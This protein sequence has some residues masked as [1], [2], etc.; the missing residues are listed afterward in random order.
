ME[1]C[2]INCVTNVNIDHISYGGHTIEISNAV[3]SIIIQVKCSVVVVEATVS[4]CGTLIRTGLSIG[5]KSTLDNHTTQT[6]PSVP[7]WTVRTR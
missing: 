4:R 6:Q 1:V 5:H 2:F 3:V 7:V